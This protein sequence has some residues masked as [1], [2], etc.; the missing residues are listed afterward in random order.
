[1]QKTTE[2]GFAPVAETIVIYES[3][4]ESSSPSLI[5]EM[6]AGLTGASPISKTTLVALC[7]VS[8]TFSS[9]YGEK[10]RF[11]ELTRV[12]QV[13]TEITLSGGVLQR[14]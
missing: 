7:P 14:V 12:T 3:G 11:D 8:S 5:E 1:M 6:G 13:R 2:D 9:M 4:S 10:E